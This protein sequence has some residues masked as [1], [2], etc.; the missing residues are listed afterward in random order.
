MVASLPLQTKPAL[1]RAS[2]PLRQ[3]DLASGTARAQSRL[4]DAPRDFLTLSDL[5][6]SAT[7]HETELERLTKH[8][9]DCNS[10]LQVDASHAEFLTETSMRNRPGS[11]KRVTWHA[12]LE[13]PGVSGAV[14][15]H[16]ARRKSIL[17]SR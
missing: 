16:R 1:V 5:T 17:I 6:C 3:E 14:T 9:T 8:N 15:Q 2:A 7:E 12:T 13:Q 10:A 4:V 11:V